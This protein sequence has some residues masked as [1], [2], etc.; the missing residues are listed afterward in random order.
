MDA[1]TVRALALAG[2]VAMGAAGCSIAENFDGCPQGDVTGAF[3]G[4]S[5]GGLDCLDNPAEVEIYTRPVSPPPQFHAEVW[6]S[7]I[8]GGN[9]LMNLIAET[10]IHFEGNLASAG[11]KRFKMTVKGYGS[12]CLFHVVNDLGE[13]LEL[14][15]G[16]N[17][18]ETVEVTVG[19]IGAGAGTRIEEIRVIGFE[20]EQEDFQAFTL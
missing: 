16:T 3:L 19:Q 14:G 2:L 5:P 9:S 12:T 8:S 17:A 15:A 6:E 7:L 18:V 13:E 11:V 1:R 20:C 10:V 4:D